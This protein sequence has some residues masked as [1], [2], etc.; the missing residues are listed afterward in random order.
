METT[1]DNNVKNKLATWNH[2]Y[3]VAKEFSKRTAYFSMEFALH[4][5]LKTYS[6]GLGFLAGSHMRSVYDLK[7]NVIGVGIL[8]KYGYYDQ[9][10]NRDQT[11]RV[12]FVE[13]NYSFLEDSGLEVEVRVNNNYQVKVRALVLKPEVFGSAPI[14]FLTTDVEGNDFLS[15]S[16]TN[17]LYDSNQET[18]VAQSIVL[19]IGGAKI[20]EALGG[21]DVYHLN[22]GHALPAFYYLQ[23]QGSKAQ[24]AFTTH[25][26]ERA[27]NVENNA[28]YLNNLGFFGERFSDEQVRQK[29]TNGDNVN[30][31]VAALRFAGTANAVS[32]LHAV[33]A[34]NMWKDFSGTAKI[35]PITN[36]QN[37]LFWQD[38]EVKKAWKKKDAKA[39]VKRKKELKKS[40]FEEVL[41]QTGKIFDPEVLTIVWAR[42]FAEY[43]RADLLLRD[44]N[45]FEEL[46]NNSERPVQI[47]WAGKPYPTDGYAID[48]FNRLVNYT[49]YRPNLAVLTGYEIGLSKKLKEGSDVW[50]NTPRIT[51]EAS[52]TSGMSAAFNGSI[53]LSTDDGWIPEFAQD[54]KN[55]FVLPAVDFNLPTQQQDYIDSNNL[56]D[57]LIEKILPTFYD[58]PSEWNKIVF[59]AIDDVVPEFT[60]ER[61]AKQY[62]KELYLQEK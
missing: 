58:K 36:A 17:N 37:L 42:R 18:R 3:K 25:T 6:G 8:W 15:R 61:M 10:R 29:M 44:L 30:H 13:K 59:K 11:L 48:V 9:N 43:K 16:I 22:E 45:R 33:V 62:Y 27:G 57:I 41:E 53:N 34:A 1:L 35:I 14:Y 26:P 19:G 20:I 60:S 40:L 47:I 21:A 5:G 56:Y 12:D 51:R 2:P 4:Q 49:K 50:L 31:T 55:C 23:N 46:L 24:M 38:D 32:K 54:E 52:G 7:Q 28:Y 39:F